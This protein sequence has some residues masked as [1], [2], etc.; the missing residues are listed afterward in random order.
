MVRGLAC[1]CWVSR[2]VKKACSVDAIRVMTGPPTT[3][4]PVGRRPGRAIPVRLTGTSRWTRVHDAPGV[5][6]VV[7][8]WRARGL[9]SDTGIVDEAAEG[10]GNDG[11]AESVAGQGHEEARFLGSPLQLVP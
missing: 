4:C 3:R 10:L 2:S 6:K 8:P 9:G 11:V 5:S 1:R 7:K